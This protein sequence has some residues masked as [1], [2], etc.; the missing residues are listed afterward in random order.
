M[1]NKVTIGRIVEF[2]PN[3]NENGLKLPN[4]MESAP[5][6]VVQV[7]NKYVNLNV[8]TADPNGNPVKQA[9][10][11]CHKSDVPLQN[12]VI[13]EGTSYWDWLPRV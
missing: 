4:N 5:A 11:V 10:S 7:F 9:W 6:M 3:K 2:H 12:E 8:F 13:G 1:E